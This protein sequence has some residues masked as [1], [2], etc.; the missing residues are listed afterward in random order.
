MM[1]VN[2]LHDG[3]TLKSKYYHVIVEVTNY[4]CA[5]HAQKYVYKVNIVPSCI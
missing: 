2:L 4:Y 1:Q 5:F 3:R